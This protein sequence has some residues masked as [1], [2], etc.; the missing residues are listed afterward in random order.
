MAAAAV[1][2]LDLSGRELNCFGIAMR[3]EAIDDW[4]SGISKTEKLGNFIESLA[5]RVVAGVA[6]V[7]VGPGIFML[8]REIQMGVTTRDHQRQHGKLQLAIALLPLFE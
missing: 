1:A 7:F 8:R 5:S 3:R 4:A 2:M 6:D